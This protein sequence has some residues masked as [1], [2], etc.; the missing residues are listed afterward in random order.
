MYHEFIDI[1]IKPHSESKDSL[2]LQYEKG[3][4]SKL[5]TENVVEENL[6]Y[7]IDGKH[8]IIKPLTNRK[9][10]IFRKIHK[11]KKSKQKIEP[12]TYVEET[13]ANYGLE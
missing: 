8:G 5:N 2:E 4:L 3:K 13:L 6:P 10:R 7:K 9:T 1:Q 12:S 11:A